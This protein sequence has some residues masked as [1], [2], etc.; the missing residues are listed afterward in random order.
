MNIWI[1]SLNL[2]NIWGTEEEFQKVFE[3]AKKACDIKKLLMKVGEIYQA[4]DKY[5]VSFLYNS[6]FLFISH[7][8]LEGSRVLHKVHK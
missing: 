5:D 3:E 7:D 8:F 1:A 6:T 4:S 2:E